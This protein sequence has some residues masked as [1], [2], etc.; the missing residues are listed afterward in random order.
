[1]TLRS[2][3][4][5]TEFLLNGS[6]P[7]KETRALL[8][9]LLAVLLF[10]LQKII[11]I[12]QKEGTWLFSV[13]MWRNHIPKLKFTFPSEVLVSSDKRPYRNWTF[14]NVSA[15]QGS[16]YCNKARL[17]F[18]AFALRDMK[19]SCTSKDELSLKFC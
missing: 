12:V 1:M 15:R 7:I 3:N 11:Y 4:H 16:S 5:M 8:I 10:L 17:N 13:F 18:Q 2:Q 9:M 6:R 14:H 19:L